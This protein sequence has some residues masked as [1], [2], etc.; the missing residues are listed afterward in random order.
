MRNRK[1]LKNISK[2]DISF[3]YHFDYAN[4]MRFVFLSNALKTLV[5]FD[6]GLIFTVILM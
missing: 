5:S 4:P 1:S 3:N 2:L 6:F